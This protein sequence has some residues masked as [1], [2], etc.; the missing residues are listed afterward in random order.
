MERPTNDKS[1]IGKAKGKEKRVKLLKDGMRDMIAI[2]IAIKKEDF[3]NK[4][5]LTDNLGEMRIFL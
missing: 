3:M 5:K 4:C 1:S 2:L